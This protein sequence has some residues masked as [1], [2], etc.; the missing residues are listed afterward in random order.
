VTQRV[1]MIVLILV[2]VLGGGLYAYKQLVPPMEEETQGPIYS[3]QPVE[4]GDISVGVETSGQLH[5]SRSGGIRA[6]GFPGGPG[7][8]VQYIIDEYLVEE[9]D[10]VKKDQV[11]A[12]LKA[13]DLKIQIENLENKLK[14]H[15]EF[16]AGLC[17]VPIDQIHQ[18]DPNE[19]I[20]LRAPIGGRVLG[21][22]IEEG[23][24]L[25]QGQ[26]VARI[27][28]DSRFK[29][30]AEL[31]ATEFAKVKKGQKLKL[32]FSQFDGFYDAT[33]TKVN[34]NPIP[35]KK[36]SGMGFV[37]RITL[38]G[39]NPGL[40]QPGMEVRVGIPVG[41]STRVNF[42]KYPAKVESFL[43]E[44]QVLSSVEAIATKVHV[45]E[46]ELVEKGDPLVSISGSDVQELIQNK[47]DEIIDEEMQL[48]QLKAQYGDLEIRAPMDGVVARFHREPGETIGPGEWLGYIYNTSDMRMWVKVDDID[49]LLVK[50]G[51]PVKV[52]VDALPGKTFEGEVTDV[53]TMG[54]DEN[55]IPRFRVNIQVKGG[56]QLRPGMQA[57]AYIDAGSAEDVLLV[58]LEAIF[59]EDGKPKVEILNPDGTT[60]VVPI[61]I[62]LMNDRVAE[63]KSGLKEGDLVITGSSA[64]LLPSQH[65]RS[66]DTILPG[67]GKDD[68]GQSGSN[69]RTSSD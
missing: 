26:I 46:M 10:E 19:G 52:T 69:N 7:N 51:A 42:F 20:T 11:I 12:R 21:L 33:I 68:S 65:I 30:V 9:G 23:N 2:I 59:E 24:E 3:T 14:N 39:E 64:D 43:K 45:E 58:P 22:N 41:D 40:V 48:N 1:I 44:E 17:S 63:V 18:I 16:L 67:N 35:S 61:E 60:K 53:A 13:P 29:V 37:Y 62:G 6:P 50:Q 34:P 36:D 25:K 31:T 56:P 66:Q 15:K 5:P 28:D 55:G 32:E 49:V 54:E 27:V 38:E 57:H 8:S 47:L 4:R